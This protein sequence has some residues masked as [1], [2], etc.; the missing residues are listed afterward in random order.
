MEQESKKAM[1]SGL[2]WMEEEGLGHMSAR[3]V[4]H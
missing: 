4:G 2:I 3:H 1:Q